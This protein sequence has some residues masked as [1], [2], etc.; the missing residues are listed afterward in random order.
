MR[1]RRTFLTIGW[2]VALNLALLHLGP[3]GCGDC[4]LEVTTTSLPDATVGVAY[5]VGLDSKCGGDAWFLT[6]GQLPP[7]IGLI[8]GGAIRGTPTTRGTYNFVVEVIDFNNGYIDDTAFQGLSLTVVEAL[9]TPRP[10]ASPTPN[11]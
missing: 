6:D 1:L 4:D 10:T 9:P 3:V 7:G 5:N 11:G 8:Q 2:F